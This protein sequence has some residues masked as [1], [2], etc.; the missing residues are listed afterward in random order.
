METP[1]PESESRR[2]RRKGQRRSKSRWDRLGQTLRN[3]WV[4]ILVAVL[5]LLAIFLLVERMNIRQSLL[6][7]VRQLIDGLGTLAD[8][9]STGALSF[10]RGTTLSDLTAYL[11]LLVVAAL[12]IWRVRWRLL[13]SPRWTE[14]ACPRCGSDLQRV[15][16]YLRDRVVSV[17]VPVARYQCRNRECHWHGLRVRKSEH[18]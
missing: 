14:L 1:A 13:T 6:T 3:W 5:V 12:V 15:H 16:R 11:L 2:R 9:L 4:E 18:E 17:I 8:N 10:V 7:W